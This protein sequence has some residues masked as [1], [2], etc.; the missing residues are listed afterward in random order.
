MN[1]DFSEEQRS[2]RESARRFLSDRVSFK[3]L[4]LAHDEGRLFDRE[5]WRD[6]A[7]LG[8]LGTAIPTSFG[9]VGLGGLELCVIAEEVGRVLAPAPFTRAIGLVAEA[10][11]R[12]GSD[13][14]QRRLLPG[15][16]TGEILPCFAMTEGPGVTEPEQVRAVFSSGRISGLKLPVVDA[17][18][19]D[20]ALA[21]CRDD[22]GCVALCLVDM[23]QTAVQ[24]QAV[25]GL[26]PLRDQAK[27]VFDSASAELLGG[28]AGS[29]AGAAT[30]SSI[31]DVA[32]VTMAFEQIGGADACLEMAR[33]YA[34]ERHVFARPIGSFQAIKHRL[35]D[36]V[37]KIELARSNAYY[38]GWAL[39]NDA[40]SLPAAA[41]TARLAASECFEFAAR[42]N[43]QIHGGIGYTWEA[44]CHPYYTRS[45]GLAVALGD[46]LVWGDRLLSAMESDVAA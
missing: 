5:L 7:G 40:A 42:E 16:A 36:M 25:K 27:V 33:A 34:L 22:A 39:A 26:D 46:N 35:A 3:G 21:V 45:R 2:L 20:V 38:A 23:H 44:D 24:V 14:Q 1:F 8:W 18:H 29:A 41:A 9:G 37:I 13:A 15:I 28:G 12:Y 4:R 17:N 30:L 31:L 11:R 43:L 10:V 32:A 19:A 6:M